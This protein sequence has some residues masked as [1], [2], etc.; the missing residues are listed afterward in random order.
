M[1]AISAK[2]SIKIIRAYKKLGS[3]RGR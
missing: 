2:R 3:E 1:I